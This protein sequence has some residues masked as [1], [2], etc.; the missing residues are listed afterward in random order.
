MVFWAIRCPWMRRGGVRCDRVG[1][2]C[3]SVLIF[4]IQILSPPT[5]PHPLILIRS[6]SPTYPHPLIPIHPIRPSS[7][8]ITAISPITI[9]PLIS[10]ISPTHPKTTTCLTHTRKHNYSSHPHTQT[11]PL[12]SPTQVATTLTTFA[13]TG[14]TDQGK[15]CR[16]CVYV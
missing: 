3:S 10:L 15:L 5:H 8:M 1:A 9:Q 14:I 12:I 11:Q 6:S 7:P 13:V 2:L 4:R 16:L